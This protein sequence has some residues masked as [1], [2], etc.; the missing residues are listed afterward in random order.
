M[1]INPTNTMKC[2][3]SF[4]ELPVP[5][6]TC[7]LG[8]SQHLKEWLSLRLLARGTMQLEVR[9]YEPPLAANTLGFW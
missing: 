7:L 8:L 5:L 9:L 6:Q 3:F 1:S 2:V 4:P